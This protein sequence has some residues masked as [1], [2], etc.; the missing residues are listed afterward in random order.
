MY[1]LYIWVADPI[2]EKKKNP[3]PDMDPDPNVKKNYLILTR[4]QGFFC[5]LTSEKP[6][7]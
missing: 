1:L 2:F 4:D 3:D 5:N 7:G 6:Q